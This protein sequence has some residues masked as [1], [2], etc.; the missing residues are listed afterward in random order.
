MSLNGVDSSSGA[1]VCTETDGY[2]E[3]LPQVGTNLIA[4][5]NA[6]GK[7]EFANISESTDPDLLVTSEKIKDDDKLVVVKDDDSVHEVV[8]NGV[9]STL[10]SHGTL[11]R[12]FNGYLT[13]PYHADKSYTSPA[14]TISATWEHNLVDYRAYRMVDDTTGFYYSF[15]SG[16]VGDE[17]KYVYND[18]QNI[19]AVYFKP[20]NGTSPFVFDLQ[21]MVDGDWVHVANLNCTAVEQIIEFDSYIYS[22]QW[23]VVVKEKSA[24]FNKLFF[25]TSADTAEYAVDTS[26]ITS[27]EI[28]SRVFRAEENVS[29]N[30]NVSNV[31]NDDFLLEKYS[32]DIESGLIGMYPLTNDSKNLKG[33]NDGI[34]TGVTYDGESVLFAGTTDSRI[35][36]SGDVSIF[37]TPQHTIS[38]WIKPDIGTKMTPVSN[39]AFFGGTG[40]GKTNN[41]GSLIVIQEDG[42]MEAVYV[43]RDVENTINSCGVKKI[44]SYSASTLTTSQVLYSSVYYNITFKVDKNKIYA[45]VN[46]ELL[47]MSGSFQDIVCNT[48]EYSIGVLDYTSS[49]YYPYKGRAK[50]LRHYNRCL[51]DSEIKTIYD[52]DNFDNHTYTKLLTSRSFSNVDITPS[53]EVKTKVQMSATGN[54]MTQ[55]DFDIM[56]EP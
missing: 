14:G 11:T 53:T 28:P 39:S 41:A 26:S 37:L 46:G 50:Y 34:D 47:C 13:A 15:T 16:S 6:V 49:F 10:V 24:A 48:K 35:S 51:T 36:L 8:I 32:D 5:N 27:G 40:A 33:T 31:A 29:F 43:F 9:T 22:D 7:F 44:S 38:I 56:R 20:Y 23:R 21:A 42:T 25:M 17:I 19:S 12:E 55:L 4:V 18:P 30:N 2:A 3:S 54:K 52:T 1:L 45:Y